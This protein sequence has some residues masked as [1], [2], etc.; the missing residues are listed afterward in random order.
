MKNWLLRVEELTKHFPVK[1]R[2]F[3]R[4][5]RFVHA[6]DD[7][8]FHMRVGDTLGLVGESGCGKTTVGRLIARLEEPDRGKIIFD[9]KE[10]L[11]LSGPELKLYRREVQMVF[12]DPF[13]SLNPRRRVKSILSQP[14][15]SYR[16]ARGSEVEARVIELL[17]IVGLRPGEM[18]L[19]RYPHE[20]SGGQRQRIGIARAISLRPRLV[21]ADEPVSSLDIS[22]RAQ[23]LNLLKELQ[24]TIG[25]SYIFISHDL[26]VVRSLCNL[27]AVMYLG[28][29]VEMGPAE[30]LFSE[31]L[32]PY[33]QALISATPIPDPSKARSKKRVIMKGDV[34]SAVGPPTGCRF[35]TRCPYQ[36]PICAEEEPPLEE[37]LPGH[38]VACHR[39]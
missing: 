5:P 22:I 16:I 25:L 4:P 39:A 38:S 14:Y 30:E 20:F 17:N 24:E 33:T 27:V 13:E 2:F 36:L 21:I 6:V 8:T 37:Q 10:T 23:I 31:P 11:H 28:K 3:G 12:Q 9:S 29:L 18:Y 19:Y 26:S 1:G 32:H 15:L 7:V 34:P 35:R